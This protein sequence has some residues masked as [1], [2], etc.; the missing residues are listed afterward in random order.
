MNAE[1]LYYMYLKNSS[2][3][4]KNGFDAEMVLVFSENLFLIT[5]LLFLEI[6]LAIFYSSG[7]DS[8][9]LC[10]LVAFLVPTMRK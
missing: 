3:S 5:A 8:T 4:E 7:K 10:Y 6:L 2:K 9:S 1:T